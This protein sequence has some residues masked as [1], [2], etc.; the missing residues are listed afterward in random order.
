MAQVDPAIQAL[1]AQHMMVQ[2]VPPTVDQ[3]GL[4]TLAPGVLNMMALAVLHMMVLVDRDTVALEALPMMGLAVLLT[5][6]REGPATQVLVDHAI[7][8][9]EVPEEDVQQYADK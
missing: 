9:R 6:G 1:V 8:A 2:A 4:A 7:Q 3:E 5:R